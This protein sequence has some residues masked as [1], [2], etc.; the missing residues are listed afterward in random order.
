MVETANTC[1]CPT[2]CRGEDRLERVLGV[3]AVA[4][5]TSW[6]TNGADCQISSAAERLPQQ[7]LHST[8]LQNSRHRHIKCQRATVS[9]SG[10]TT[11]LDVLDCRSFPHQAKL[12]K[13]GGLTPLVSESAFISLTIKNTASA[14]IAYI[15]AVK[16]RA[17]R[18]RPYLAA[19]PRICAT[20]TD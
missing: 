8:H 2:R 20:L 4:S 12:V 6:R 11:V 1:C 9:K 19:S 17:C 3:L 18:D 15:A 16:H 14:V 5:R 13:P 7:A 10:P